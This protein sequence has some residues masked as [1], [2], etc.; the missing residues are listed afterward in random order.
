MF[1]LRPFF[2]SCQ[3]LGRP[4]TFGTVCGCLSLTDTK[5]WELVLEVESAFVLTD[6]EFTL[7]KLTSIFL[8]MYRIHQQKWTQTN[9]HHVKLITSLFVSMV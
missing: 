4:Q 8:E 3:F 7:T 9:T 6:S 1:K 2:T 5:F